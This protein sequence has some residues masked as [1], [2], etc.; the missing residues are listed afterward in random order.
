MG[1]ENLEQGNSQ[2]EEEEADFPEIVELPLEDVLDLH[3]F[4]PKEIPDLVEDYIQQAYQAGFKQ[5][6]IIHG[7]GKGV[8]RAIVHSILKRNPY[9]EAL[10]VPPLELGGWGVTLVILKDS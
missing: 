7:K 8:Q 3:T 6:R 4:L 5:V 9:V 10:K 2:R 1:D